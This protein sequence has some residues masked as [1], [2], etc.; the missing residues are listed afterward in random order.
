MI[1]LNA[2]TN[3]HFDFGYDPAGKSDDDSIAVSK[4]KV[5]AIPHVFV[6]SRDGKIAATMNGGDEAELRK[7]LAK[8]GVTAK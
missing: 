3:Y 4:Y 2:G 8:Q 7:A 5:F 6:I 1:K